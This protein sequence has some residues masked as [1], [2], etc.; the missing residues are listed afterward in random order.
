MKRLLACTAAAAI[1]TAAVAGES[2]YTGPGSNRAALSAERACAPQVNEAERMLG[3]VPSR[4]SRRG[5]VVRQLQ[6]ARAAMRDGDAGQC[7]SYARAARQIEADAGAA[8]RPGRGPY[9]RPYSPYDPQ[10]PYG[11][12]APG[13]PGA[14]PPGYAGPYGGYAPGYRP[15]TGGDGAPW[16]GNP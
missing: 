2:P 6:Y 7:L 8:P 10:V 5:E 1:A 14:Y 3:Y 12:P 4:D 11:A 16:E 13:Y 9:G 15:P